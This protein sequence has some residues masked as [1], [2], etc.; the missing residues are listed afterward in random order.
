MRRLLLLISLF[1]LSFGLQ[2]Q[3]PLYSSAKI[4]FVKSSSTKLSKFPN[5]SLTTNNLEIHKH[6]AGNILAQAFLGFV[7]GGGLAIIPFS[8]TIVDQGDNNKKLN[9]NLIIL[10]V[11]SYTGGV[12]LGVHWAAKAENPNHSFWLTHVSSLLSL[13]IGTAIAFSGIEEPP[14]VTSVIAGLSPIIGSIIYSTSI[15]D[16]P[17]ESKNI[18][19][20]A[21]ILSH[22]DL[23]NS[24]K[25]F[26]IELLRIGL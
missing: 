17:D 9:T 7:V 25:M 1:Y 2:A 11:L 14:Y 13:G 16:W 4:D 15:A 26:E 5:D 8:A 12:S 6:S 20:Q 22:K 3:Q 21:K 19:F 23:V 10:S 18:T 24:S